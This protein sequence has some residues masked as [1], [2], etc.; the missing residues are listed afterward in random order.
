MPVVTPDTTQMEDL[1]PIEPGTYKAKVTACGSEK[2]KEAGTPMIVPKFDVD[3]NGKTKSRSTYLVIEGKGT[4]GFDQ[5][6]RA[7]HLDSLADQYKDPNVSPKP[8][9]DTDTLIGQEL[10]VNID[11]DIYKG[12][13]RDRIVGFLRA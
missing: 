6:L 3:V 10:M 7:V 2:S 1:S 4:W 11:S 13:V 8:P 12:T 5:F 9:F